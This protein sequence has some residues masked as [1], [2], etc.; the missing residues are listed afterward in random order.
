MTS[1]DG[2]CFRQRPRIRLIADVPD[3]TLDRQSRVLVERLG[4]EFE[5]SRGFPGDPFNDDDYDLIYPLEWHL[6]H[7]ERIGC[8]DK[9][10]TGIRSHVF[11]TNEVPESFL[12]WLRQNFQLIH[13]VSRRLAAIF[14][15]RLPNVVHVTHGM[16][17]RLF[18]PGIPTDQS[19]RYLRLG[20]GGS[21]ETS[22]M[23]LEAFLSPL[24]ELPGVEL[25][26]SDRENRNLPPEEMRAFFDSVD[27]YLCSSESEGNSNLLL[28]AAAM[29]RAIITTDVGAVPEYLEDGESAL[30][31]ERTV[32]SLVRAV[33]TLRDD[34]SQR[35]ALGRRARAAVLNG[36]D[37]TNRIEGFRRFF[38]KAL[39]SRRS[40]TIQ[41]PARPDPSPIS[42]CIITGGTRPQL[43]DT[44]IRSIRAQE[45]PEYE[46][47]VVGRHRDEPGITTIHREDY[48]A[49]GRLGAMRNLA[50]RKARHEN[51]VMLDDDIVLSRDWYSN[52]RAYGEAFDILTSQVRL[53]NG[54]RYWDHA[55]CNGPLGQQLL[56]EDEEAEN[57]YMTG[58][59]G[60]V[61][62][63]RVAWTVRWDDWRSTY[64]SEDIDFADRCHIKG[65]RVSHNHRSVVFHADPTYTTVGRV[66]FRSKEDRTADWLD[67]NTRGL[68]ALELSRWTRRQLWNGQ[69]ADV[70]DLMRY[71]M[72]LHPECE[73]FEE[74]WKEL[75]EVY[76][77]P[78]SDARWSSTEDPEYRATMAAYQHVP[79]SESVDLKPTTPPPPSTRVVPSPKDIPPTIL[80]VP[81]TT[82]QTPGIDGDLL[83]IVPPAAT[84]DKDALQQA[85]SSIR[86][87]PTIFAVIDIPSS[88]EMA[89]L[90]LDLLL[91][92]EQVSA[93]LLRTEVLSKCCLSVPFQGTLARAHAALQVACGL[94]VIRSESSIASGVSSDTPGKKDLERFTRE[95]LRAFAVED[96]YPRIRTPEGS[97]ELYSSVMDCAAELLRRGRYL[98][99]FAMGA[100]AEALREGRDQGLGLDIDLPTAPTPSVSSE[101]LLRETPNDPLVSI[102]VPTFNRPAMLA[103]ALKSVARQTMNDLEVIV[104][105]DGGTDPGPTLNGLRD[106]IGG[107]ER[108]SIVHHDRNRGLAAARNTGLR[109]ARGRYVGF[110][111]DDDRLLP[112]HLTAL[113]PQL[114]L[115]ARIVHGDARYALE[116][117]GEALPFTLGSL[118][119]YQFDFDTTF[120]PLDNKFPV[121]SLLFERELLFEA[122]G[123][124][125]TLPV[126]EDW[127]LWLRA[128]EIAQPVRV[129]RI[130][131]EVRV[132]SGEDNMTTVDPTR[133]AEVRGHI[134]GKTL[135]LEHQDPRLRELR[136]V[137]LLDLKKKKGHPFPRKAEVWLR[138]TRDL[139]PID[140]DNPLSN[141]N[142]P[143]APEPRFFDTEKSGA[144]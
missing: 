18:S 94:E 30:I 114:R 119:H 89:S 75:Q 40:G 88:S 74:S 120:F 102:I 143:I 27:A 79:V 51:I 12:I 107:G 125:E 21:P 37:W 32:P 53:P 132:R 36:W 139:R 112:N 17:T 117:G 38:R 106:S 105:N 57:L 67:K 2:G 78:L 1:A 58:G 28:E 77:G 14:Q 60:W 92:P 47:I 55:T 71:G 113:L 72:Q 62:K 8:P 34:P 82:T 123:F 44:L 85:V 84:I 140:P 129:R 26:L 69:I 118:V 126:L 124:D 52:F 56:E 4:D 42:F 64:E 109:M 76:G 6:V 98:G 138:G 25:V 91:H 81:R 100:W 87:D 10:V 68:S 141:P 104:V 70:A 43:L 131:S 3:G 35:L 54:G 97:D 63:Q 13:V 46:I 19:G 39:A 5:F 31:V 110:L 41:M 86:C 49:A 128:F 66:V 101:G 20:W 61:M 130:T 133:W 95:A 127:D 142:E 29:A 45:I 15:P 137:H 108:L 103:R 23:E 96:L 22:T 7:T 24:A 93:V 136:I 50:V 144:G 122:G 65:F 116:E 135:D 11:R 9:Y 121:Q 73:G 90:Y 33:E 16:D 134:Y 111:D 115:G 48:A 80:E 99:G 59:G 83:L